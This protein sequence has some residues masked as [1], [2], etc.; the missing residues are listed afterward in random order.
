MN[1]YLNAEKDLST[2]GRVSLIELNNDNPAFP[3]ISGDATDA[4]SLAFQ[5]KQLFGLTVIRQDDPIWRSLQLDVNE[6]YT[7]E[8]LSAIRKSLKSDAVI[9][10]KVITFNPYPQMTIGLRLKL[11]DLNS[12][13]MLWAIEQVWDTTDKNVEE[14]IKGYYEDKGI[15]SIFTEGALQEK[16]GTISSLKFI[17]FVADE[18]AGTLQKKK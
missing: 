13:Q 8:Q 1:Y 12:G 4:L 3:Q 17:K 16:I 10:G 6:N 18:T 14:R 5:K 2:I 11:I 15:T 7:L 9:I